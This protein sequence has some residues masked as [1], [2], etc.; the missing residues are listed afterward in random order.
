MSPTYYAA[1]ACVGGSWGFRT[2][3][4]RETG[5]PSEGKAQAAAD[6]ARAEDLQESQNGTGPIAGVLKAYFQ[7]Q[8]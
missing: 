6:A 5:Y 1:L 7:G 8:P 3:T 4:K 2:P